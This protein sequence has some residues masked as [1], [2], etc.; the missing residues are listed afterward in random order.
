[1][2]GQ[3]IRSRA[4]LPLI[5]LLLLAAAVALDVAAGLA[6]R[7]EFAIGSLPLWCITA[8]LYATRPRRFAA[9]FTD[10]ALEVEVPPQT[11]PYE[12]MQGLL[13]G[14]RPVDPVRKGARTFPIRVFHEDGVLDIP[15]ETDVPSDDVY[16]YL[17]FKIP[18]RS[19]QPVHADLADHLRRKQREHGVE[20]VWTYGPRTHAGRPFPSRALR[21]CAALFVSGL[22]WIVY[23]ALTAGGEPWLIF[24][25]V[26]SVFSVL[27]GAILAA[28]RRLQVARVKNGRASLVISP[29]G[30]AVLQGSLT[31]EMRWDE[32]IDVSLA[33]KTGAHQFGTDNT[34]GVGGILLKVSGIN[35]LLIDAFDRPLPLIYYQILRCVRGG[36]N[37]SA[38][39]PARP[40]TNESR[41]ITT[42]ES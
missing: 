35:I 1:M 19:T 34:P 30:L 29:D 4:S 17:Y 14:G 15:A 9:T 24:G 40:A 5:V 18:A 27:F 7:S 42:D 21:V 23:G 25:A 37:D 8:A 6:G 10:T 31:G 26:L 2:T 20:R 33:A 32:M 22:G 39:P 38:L 11:I 12:K 16:R 36:D 28:T 13:A 3:T 41:G